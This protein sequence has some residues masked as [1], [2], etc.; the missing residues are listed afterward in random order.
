MKL[1]PVKSN[2]EL[3]ERLKRPIQT[4][5]EPKKEAPK[6]RKKGE[7]KLP[8]DEYRPLLPPKRILVR[9][10][11]SHKDPTKKVKHY[12]EFS[13]KRFGDSNDVENPVSVYIQGYQESEFYTGYL[14]GRTVSFPL[15]ALYEVLDELSD[16]SEECD[17]KGIE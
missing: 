6:K 7:N 15:E 5:E 13:V 8:P 9:E 11:Y 16:L 14:K 1:K 2:K 4:Q 10:S 17:K 3:R 12:L